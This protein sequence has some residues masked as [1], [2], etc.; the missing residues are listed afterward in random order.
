MSQ[1]SRSAAFHH[2]LLR[3]DSTLPDELVA[4]ARTWLADGMLVDVA[5]AVVFTAMTSRVALSPADIALLRETLGETG[6]DTD[7]LAE[8]ETATAEVMPLYGLAPVG[9]EVLAEHGEL[10]PYNVDLTRSDGGPAGPDELDAALTGAVGDAA[11]PVA[12]WRCWRYPALDTQW[13]PAKR[14]YLVYAAD[15]DNLPGITARLQ[16]VLSDAG[17]IDPLVTVF[18]DA[19]TLPMFQRTALGF[20]AL[21]W[22]AQPQPEIRIARLLEPDTADR[23]E[24]SLDPDERDG[25][26][27]YLAQGVPL[28]ITTTLFDDAVDPARGASVPMSFRTDGT[29]VWSDAVAYYLDQHGLAPTADFTAHIR[30]GRYTVPEV[31]VL[32]LHRALAAVQAPFGAHVADPVGLV[33]G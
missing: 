31:D 15:G 17:E 32:S 20:A 8:I 5:Q 3:V 9:P 7:P 26:L 4:E 16:R 10:I 24:E 21:L 13:P 2:L 28:V 33:T 27:R 6:G 23:A 1:S 19:D 14:M 12:L 18:A 11:G 30:S 25:V 22:T 29:W